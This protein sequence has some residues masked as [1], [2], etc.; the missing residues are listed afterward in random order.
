MCR[1]MKILLFLVV[2]C[3]ACG[4]DVAD[5]SDI[6]YDV[7]GDAHLA[8]NDTTEDVFGPATPICPPVGPAGVDPGDFLTDLEL[9]DCD[10]NMHRL[11][12]L[13]GARAGF[14]NLL[15]GG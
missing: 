5:V 9:P 3:A 4:T 2:L 8:E 11:H 7:A 10:G 14:V 12:D 13:C 6:I 1:F 15:S